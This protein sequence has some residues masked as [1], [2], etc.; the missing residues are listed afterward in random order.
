VIARWRIFSNVAPEPA[1]AAGYDDF[2]T[3]ISAADV[4][5]LQIVEEGRDP[6]SR[7]IGTLIDAAAAER[8]SV[9]PAFGAKSN[10]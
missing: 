6:R 3:H 1:G 5:I 2:I 9:S 4:A 8:N 10:D 7:T